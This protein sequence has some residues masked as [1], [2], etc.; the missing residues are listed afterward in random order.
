M[1]EENK[2]L[3]ADEPFEFEKW[4][5]EG[6]GLQEKIANPSRGV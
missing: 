3:V 1:N 5:V 2:L 6:Q 4:L